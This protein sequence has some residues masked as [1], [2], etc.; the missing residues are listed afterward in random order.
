MVRSEKVVQGMGPVDTG[1]IVKG[2]EYERGTR[3]LLND[4]EMHRS[5]SRPSGL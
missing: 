3:V 4:R 1:K 5:S 2:Y